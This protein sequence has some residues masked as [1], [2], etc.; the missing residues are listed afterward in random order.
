[1]NL[2]TRAAS[3][4]SG[5][6]FKFWLA[7]CLA[8]AACIPVAY[9]KGRS[10][11]AAWKQAQFDRATTKAITKARAADEAANI[12]RAADTERTNDASERREEAAAAGGRTAVNCER[13]RAAY[14]DRA[15]PACD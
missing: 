15:I 8:I 2:A 7:L 13:L 9:C 12:R 10:D 4:L 6:T 5:F 3:Y 11:G 1:M 14:P